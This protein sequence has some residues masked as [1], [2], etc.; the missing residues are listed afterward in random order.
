[1][2]V[3]TNP[4]IL[5]V[6]A[7]FFLIIDIV[8]IIVPI[9]LII[10][11]I[12][13]FSKAM[14]SNDE[15]SQK[16]CATLFFKRLFYAV[17]VFATPWIIEVLMITLGDLLEKEGTTNYADCIINS[18]NIAYYEELANIKQKE[19]DEKKA[20]EQKSAN[21]NSLE[22][23]TIKNNSYSSDS[24]SSNSSSGNFIGQ[25]YNLTDNQLRGIA[26]LCQQEQGSAVGAAAEASLMANQ[27]ELFGSKYG[28]G[29]SG[30]YNY[31]AKSGWFYKAE[32][33]MAQ[34]D[35][36]RQ[37]VYTAVYNV[38]VLGKRTLP[39]YINEHDCIKCGHGFDIIKLVIDG[40]TITDENGLLNKN[41]Y[42]K[43]KTTIYNRYSS[44]YTF[45]TF[46]TE[47]SDP[48]GYTESAK[49]K[50]DSLNGK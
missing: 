23:S 3:C 34:T 27:F 39:L 24:S 19:E 28:T 9:G 50:Y 47:H 44:I 22:T 48:F 7:F 21:L 32:H 30:L 10:I 26:R 20:N 8:K 15:G 46:P 25:K 5:K 16:K 31:V 4:D 17:L 43:N 49:K 41:N 33:F 38:L 45:Y 42:I 2:D 6:I 12:I 37:D 35:S 29:G 40:S 13:D 11:G 14:I 18:E 1:M 36:L